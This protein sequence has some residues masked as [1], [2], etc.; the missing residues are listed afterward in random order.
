MVFGLIHS[1]Y[2]VGWKKLKKFKIHIIFIC[3]S[4]Y[5]E[6]G[7]FRGHSNVGYFHSGYFFLPCQPI[8]IFLHNYVAKIFAFSLLLHKYARNLFSSIVNCN[9]YILS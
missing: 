4:V 3:L 2:S 6:Y 1:I 5:G 9:F 7:E 8:G